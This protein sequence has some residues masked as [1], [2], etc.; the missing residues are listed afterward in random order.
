[1]DDCMK[2]QSEVQLQ[3]RQSK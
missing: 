3:N 2:G 1:M